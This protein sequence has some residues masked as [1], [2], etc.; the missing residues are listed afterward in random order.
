[1]TEPS[2]EIPTAEPEPERPRNPFS[3]RFSTPLLLGSTFNP[4]NSSL[5]ATGLVGIG[6]DLSVRPGQTALLVS[7]LYLCSSVAQPTMG[8]LSTIFGPRRVFLSGAIILVIAGVI[9]TLAP[10]FGYLLV[11]RALIGI[12]TS[13]AYPTAMALARR[14]ADENGIGVPT[15]FLGNLSIAGQVMAS[16]G[17][18][19]GGVL[20][21]AF[22]W[23]ALFFINIPL[24][25]LSIAL[26]LSGVPRDGRLDRGGAGS[27]LRRID[28]PGIALFAGTVVSLLIFL[29]DL[30]HPAWWLLGVTIVLGVGMVL[31]ERRSSSPLIDV[32][33]LARNQPLQ[34]T[35][36]RQILV[37]L[38]S[39]SVLYGVSQ[40]MELGRGLGASQV[41]LILLPLTAVGIILARVISNR[42][43]VR[44]PLLLSGAVLIVA[45][46]LEQFVTHETSIPVLIGLTVLLG[47]T[48]GFAGFANQATL[49]ANAPAAEI[50]VASGLYRTALYTGAIFSASLIGIVFGGKPT[51][52]GLHA[53]SWVQ[54]GLGAALV[55]LVAFDRRI[56][57][58]AKK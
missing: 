42:G 13:A 21:G 7:V 28:V 14:R 39:Y 49:Y 45:A 4:I 12:G 6:V 24:G 10:G 18:P 46:G 33:M 5:L 41:G 26:T 23:R 37:S 17:L 2:T 47:T 35:Y 20:T 53:L 16:V 58:V 50:A 22:G 32:R 38:A 56:P 40:W 51:D 15:R 54:L 55:L 29:G 44:V 8:K 43:W 9:G 52:A 31:W 30:A 36:L 3:A 34:R 1:M 48:N 25:L 57:A 19:L 11:S 27:V